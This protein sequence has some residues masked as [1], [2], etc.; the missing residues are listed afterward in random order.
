[1]RQYRCISSI[2][3]ADYELWSQAGVKWLVAR[4]TSLL[5]VS[6]KL[7]IPLGSHHCREIC[8][9][10]PFMIVMQELQQCKMPRINLPV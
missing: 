7:L 5:V 10:Y 6:V 2:S 3:D 8:S 1:M 9:K 4:S